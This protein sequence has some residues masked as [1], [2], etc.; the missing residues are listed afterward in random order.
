VCGHEGKLVFDG[1]G[2]IFSD[3]EPIF[4]NFYQKKRQKSGIL[5]DSKKYNGEIAP[6]TANLTCVCVCALPNRGS[7]VA[8][9][10]YEDSFNYI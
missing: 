5:M 4:L 6:I 3:F 10:I 9:E 7:Y 2:L 1:F 8:R